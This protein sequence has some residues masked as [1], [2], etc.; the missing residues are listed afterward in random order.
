VELGR[1]IKAF[2]VSAVLCYLTTAGSCLVDKMLLYPIVIHFCD[3]IAI[4]VQCCVHHK[5]YFYGPDKRM[6]WR[7][8]VDTFRAT[9]YEFYGTMVPMEVMINA[10]MIGIFAW[11]VCTYVMFDLLEMEKPDVCSL[12][13]M[14]LENGRDK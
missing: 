5:F 8:V 12:S 9:C 3:F 14:I 10:H 1:F 13:T 6:R 11:Y 4:F 7:Q 2:V